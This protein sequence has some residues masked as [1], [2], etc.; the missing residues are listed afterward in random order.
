M[1]LIG[2]AMVGL[3]MVLMIGK[4]VTS[5]VATSTEVSA[6]AVVYALVVGGLA[7][8]ELTP[9]SLLQLFVRSASMAGSVLFIVAAASSVSFALTIQQIPQYLSDALVALGHGYGAQAFMIVAALL[10]IAFGAVLEGAP[11]LIIFGPLLDSD[12][13]AA[14][15]ASP[16]LRHRHGDRHGTGAVL[17]AGRAGAVRHLRDHRHPLAGRRPADGEVSPGAVPGTDGAGTGAGVLALVA[18]AV[19]A[20][21]TTY[22]P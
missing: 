10:M 21:L 12:R 20:K 8:R 15:R 1:P 17:S 13:S 3:V 19:R 22:V 7:F 14:R 9:H 11:A 5:G 6:F 16:A 4:G 18:W 2:G